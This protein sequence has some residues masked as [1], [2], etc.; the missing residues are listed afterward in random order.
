[1]SCS[2]FLSVIKEKIGGKRKK[3]I[4]EKDKNDYE[5]SKNP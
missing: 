3:K 5:I 4:N 1:M 2:N